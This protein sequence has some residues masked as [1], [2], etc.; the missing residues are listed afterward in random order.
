MP[1]HIESDFKRYITVT[2]KGWVRL[3]E[4]AWSRPKREAAK[5]SAAI[6]GAR[7]NRQVGGVSPIMIRPQHLRLGAEQVDLQHGQYPGQRLAKTAAV[8]AGDQ[9]ALGIEGD[10]VDVVVMGDVERPLVLEPWETQRM[11]PARTPLSHE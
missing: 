3:T 2:D 10:R 9:H 7:A 1:D 6:T 5:N 11:N 8:V 4:A